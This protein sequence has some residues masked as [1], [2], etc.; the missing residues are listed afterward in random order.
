MYTEAINTYS[1]ERDGK[2]AQREQV[3]QRTCEVP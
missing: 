3:Q 2:Q 1:T